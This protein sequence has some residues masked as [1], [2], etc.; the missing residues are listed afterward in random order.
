MSEMIHKSPPLS[1]SLRLLL[2][3]DSRPPRAPLPGVRKEFHV[4]RASRSRFQFN[5]ALFSLSGNVILADFQAVRFFA[6]K[7]NEKRDPARFPGRA[8][9]A[10]A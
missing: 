6:Q 7:L 9:Q 5:Q 4:S 1:L 8:V 10:G 3:E 2:L